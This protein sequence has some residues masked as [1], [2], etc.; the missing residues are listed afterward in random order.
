MADIAILRSNSARA[1]KVCVRDSSGKGG[2]CER[3]PGGSLQIAGE[4]S[5]EVLL[6]VFG[7]EIG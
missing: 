4:E 2:E 3:T 6:D 5:I 1:G 7:G